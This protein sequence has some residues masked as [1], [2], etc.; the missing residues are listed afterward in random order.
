MPKENASHPPAILIKGGRILTPFEEL[1][2]DIL[3][4]GGRIA[5]VGKNLSRQATRNAVTISSKGLY[6]A[7]GLIDLHTQGGCGFDVWEGTP[8]SLEGWSRGNAR[9]GVTSYL[10]TTGYGTSGYD[11][12]AAHIDRAGVA[13]KPLGVYLE[14]PFCSMEKKGGIDA[15]RVGPVSVKLLDR[16]CRSLGSN[17]RMMTVAPERPGALKIIKELRRRGVI[18]AIGHTDCTWEQVLPAIEAGAT[19]VTH[20]FNTMRSLHHREPG[21]LP[22]LLTD[23]RLTIELILDGHHIHPA[24]V[25]LAV[26]VK[27]VNRTCVITDNIRMAGM[28]VGDYTYERMGRKIIVT[29]GVPRLVDGT[30]AGSTLTMDRALANVVA[31]TGMSVREVMPMLTATPA[32]VVG[33]GARKGQIKR[34]FDADIVLFNNDFRIERTLVEGRTVYERE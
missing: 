26:R 14:S 32:G 28:P 9:H 7:P 27:G 23:P 8:A 34:G 16:I 31:F 12:M 33:F 15:S 10:I 20:C 24:V 25:N 2:G 30:I 17:L 5:R 6:V 18:A 29:G 13:S 22:A 11:Y 1:T 21:P 3:I 19:H 4:A